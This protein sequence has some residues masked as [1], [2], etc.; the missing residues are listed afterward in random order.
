MPTVTVLTRKPINRRGLTIVDQQGHTIAF[1]TSPSKWDYKDVQRWGQTEREGFKAISRPRG[2]GLRTLS[3]SINVFALDTR[4]DVERQI[5]DFTNIAARGTVIRIKG[6]SPYYQGPCWWYVKDLSLKAERLTPAG[7]VTQ[8]VIDVSL[9]EYVE[10]PTKVIKSPPP[11]KPPARPVKKPS[12]APVK[13]PV[14]RWYTV[15]KGDSLSLIAGRYLGNI[16]KWPV[17]YSLNRAAVGPN[18][19]LIRPGLRLKIPP[20]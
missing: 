11:S 15:V 2:G 13:Q 7:K 10:P 5:V 16:M 1:P 19:N 8:G 20:K 3:F 4:T 14:Y 6:G 12:P 18:P 9:E 17:L